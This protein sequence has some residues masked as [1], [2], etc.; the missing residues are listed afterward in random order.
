MLKDA[1]RHSRDRSPR[2]S[3][4][5]LVHGHAGRTR[6]ESTVHRSDELLHGTIG[7]L[8]PPGVSGGI[9]EYDP[10][11]PRSVHM[12]VGCLRES[13]TVE[14]VDVGSPVTYMAEHLPR[15]GL[16]EIGNNDSNIFGL[17]TRR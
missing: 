8:V 1:C 14:M 12:F 11:V 7:L 15:N 10:L 4:L 2:D 17:R 3:Y 6:L 16:I 5:D 9:A 13:R